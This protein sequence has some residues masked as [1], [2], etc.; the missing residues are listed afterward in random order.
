MVFSTQATERLSRR[1]QKANLNLWVV[2]ATND[3]WGKYLIF[4]IGGRCVRGAGWSLREAQDIVNDIISQ[5][6][7][8]R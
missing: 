5:Q 6:V 7:N 8:S 3:S 4:K 1:L 2:R